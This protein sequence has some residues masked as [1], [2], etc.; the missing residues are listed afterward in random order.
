MVLGVLGLFV[1]DQ[2]VR[3]HP[4]QR[5]DKLV[6]KSLAPNQLVDAFEEA[7]ALRGEL[8]LLDGGLGCQVPNDIQHVFY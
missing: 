1:T 4:K 5:I 3:V 2:D 6:A 8:F 7:A